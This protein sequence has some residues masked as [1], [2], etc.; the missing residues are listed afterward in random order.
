MCSS[1]LLPDPSKLDYY[2][3]IGI[4]EVVLRVPGGS[5]DEVLPVLDRI[6]AVVADAP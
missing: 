6:A 4:T 2:A 1:D 3:Q 5:R